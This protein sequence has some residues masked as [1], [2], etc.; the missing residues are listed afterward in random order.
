MKGSGAFDKRLKQ[1]AIGAITRAY[2][3]VISNIKYTDAF[4]YVKENKALCEFDNITNNDDSVRSY[5]LLKRYIKEI[6]KPGDNQAANYK[7]YSIRNM[8]SIYADKLIE[9]GS[10]G[11][12]F[13]MIGACAYANKFPDDREILEPLT[14]Y[15]T[16][17]FAIHNY[18]GKYEDFIFACMNENIQHEIG[19]I[20]YDAVSDIEIA[21]GNKGEDS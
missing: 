14:E 10:W 19:D 8:Y 16:T 5:R 21:E 17:L 6:C 18:I 7:Y 11:N 9:I 2:K 3:D 4:N 15:I 1:A 20:I 13:L 12:L